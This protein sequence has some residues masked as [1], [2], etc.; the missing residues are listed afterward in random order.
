MM[1]LRLPYRIQIPLG[2]AVAVLTTALLVTAAGARISARDAR[3]MTLAALDRA[4]VLLIAQTRPYLASDDVWRVF[5]LLRDMVALLPGAEQSRLRVAV[6]DAQG[7]VF[8]ASHPTVLPTGK[9]VL[10]KTMHG[11]LLAAP[12]EIQQRQRLERIN[13]GVILVDAITSEDGQTLGF[14]LMD[15]DAPVFAANWA[16]L[17][18]P[19][20]IGVGLA[21]VVLVPAGWWLGRRMTAPVVRLARFITTLEPSEVARA[22]PV[23]HTEDPELQRIERALQ[24]LQSAWH[25]R[26]RAEQRALS[27]ERL[28]A[29]GRMTAAVAHEINNPLAG[30]LTA[31][32]TLRVHGDSPQARARALDVIE[33]GLLQIRAT[34]AALLPQ[35]RVQDRALEPTDFDD[36]LTLAQPTAQTLGVQVTAN[37][38]AECAL[39]VPSAPFRQAML[40][41]VLNAIKAAGPGGAVSV[42]LRA[43]EQELHL[44]VTN[45]G[46][47]LSAEDLGHILAQEDGDDPRGFGLWVCQQIAHRHQG[48]FELDTRYSGGTRFVL[49]L[50]N[51]EQAEMLR[52]N[53]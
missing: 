34:V 39:R 27:S 22:Q 50:P 18:R 12:E 29:V 45:S 24:S 37:I 15:V 6:L 7:R 32:R 23:P 43:N 2:L 5:A 3:A 52:K 48:R 49:C 17:A 41:M 20:L 28:A 30:L 19:A 44:V 9:A 31:T 26:R 10:G 33:K 51:R 42:E 35:A 4:M 13:G 8:A 40:N 1:S 53:T 47:V 14:V 38:T 36:V 21:V 11:Q 46:A 25:A 16:Q